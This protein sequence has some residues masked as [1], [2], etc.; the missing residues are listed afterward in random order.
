MSAY[1][2][3]YVSRGY[4]ERTILEKI[5]HLDGSTLDEVIEG[6]IGTTPDDGDFHI[7]RVLG[8]IKTASDEK[9]GNVLDIFGRESLYNYLITNDRDAEFK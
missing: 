2:T 1:S 7:K 4:A 6:L 9:L 3:I 8:L 5:T